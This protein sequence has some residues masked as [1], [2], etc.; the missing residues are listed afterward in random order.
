[1]PQIT[2]KC[3]DDSTIIDLHASINVDT[4]TDCTSFEAVFKTY[5]RGSLTDVKAQVEALSK[6]YETGVRKCLACLALQDRRADVFQFCLD[7]RNFPYESYFVDGANAVPPEEDPEDFKVLE[8]PNFR[9]IFPQKP[10][11]HDTIEN[12]HGRK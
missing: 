1:M 9:Q 11:S 6:E 5:R 2:D 4:S 7:K 10:K 3:I 12:D 8:E